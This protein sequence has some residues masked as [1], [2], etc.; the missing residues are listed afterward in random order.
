MPAHSAKCYV[1]VLVVRSSALQMKMLNRM[2]QQ[3]PDYQQARGTLMDCQTD[4]E[5]GTMFARCSNNVYMFFLAC[6]VKPILGLHWRSQEQYKEMEV[7]LQGR[8]GSGTD[9]QWKG[10][11]APQKGARSPGRPPLAQVG[12]GQMTSLKLPSMPQPG[13]FW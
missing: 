3:L 1:L 4:H 7:A 10:R 6:A 12:L 2:Q 5:F 9:R 13:L 8:S 11:F